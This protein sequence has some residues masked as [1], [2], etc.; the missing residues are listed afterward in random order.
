MTSSTNEVVIEEDIP[1][2]VTQN[3]KLPNFNSKLMR[4]KWIVEQN[5]IQFVPNMKSFNVK[6]EKGNVYLV[7]LKPK[8]SCTCV[9]NENCCHILSVKLSI[10]ED[11]KTKKII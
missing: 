3:D 8:P 10:G 5:L 1:E 4:A 7:K 6:D 11:V 9:E 2:S